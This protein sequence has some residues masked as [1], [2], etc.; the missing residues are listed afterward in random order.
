[1]L[2]EITRA[3]EYISLPVARSLDDMISLIGQHASA[4]KI[5]EI[6]ERLQSKKTT[7]SRLSLFLLSFLRAAVIK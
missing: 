1:M 5:K 4:G 7:Y 2:G 6:K 3:F